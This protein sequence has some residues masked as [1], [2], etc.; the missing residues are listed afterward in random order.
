MLTATLPTL[1]REGVLDARTAGLL[2]LL[3]EGGVPLVVGGSAP[4]KQRQQLAVALQSIDPGSRW[5]L[6]DA[7]EEP[8]T[9]ERLAALLLG[10]SG[11]GLIVDAADLEGVMA[12]LQLQGLPEDAVRRLGV[13]VIADET[14]AGLR[15]VVVHYLRPTE[16]DAQGHVQRRPPAVLTAWDDEGDRFDD[17]AWGITPELADRVD[18]AQA[19]LEERLADRERFL[20]GLPT[21]EDAGATEARVREYLEREPER[22]PAPDRDAAKPS[23]FKQGL[24]DADDHS[25]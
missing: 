14:A 15:C 22:V 19:D 16:R 1:L 4:A 23:P 5:V 21:A 11:L 7:N 20:A 18:R 10:G 9:T 6:L 2:W 24:L 17:Y 12:R 25:H 3:Q 13:V 8:V